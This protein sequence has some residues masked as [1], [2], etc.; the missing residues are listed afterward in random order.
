[1]KSGTS[2]AVLILAF[3][4]WLLGTGVEVSIEKGREDLDI[5][6]H[7]ANPLRNPEELPGRCFPAPFN[8]L[9]FGLILDLWRMQRLFRSSSIPLTPCGYF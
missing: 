4:V 7:P 3:E 6:W 1:M 8:K 9:Y 2:W 5:P